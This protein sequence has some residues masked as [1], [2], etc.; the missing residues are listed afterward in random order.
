MKHFKAHNMGFSL[1]EVVVA[2][3]MVSLIIIALFNTESI[4]LK[5]SAQTAHHIHALVAIQNRFAEIDENAFSRISKITDTTITDPPAVISYTTKPA[6]QNGSLQRVEN[7]FVEKITASWHEFGKDSTVAVI[8][9]VYR[10]PTHK[11]RVP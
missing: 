6:A 1:I 5:S 4:L 7:M 9:Y 2:L 8:R 10:P 3:L 11:E